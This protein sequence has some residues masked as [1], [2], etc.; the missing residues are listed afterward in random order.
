MIEPFLD[1]YYSVMFYFFCKM[2]IFLL[3]ITIPDCHFF[4]FAFWLYFSLSLSNLFSPLAFSHFCMLMIVICL[5]ELSKR[6]C[7]IHHIFGPTTPPIIFHSNKSI[8]LLCNNGLVLQISNT[9]HFRRRIL[10]TSM[11]I[12]SDPFEEY[13]NPLAFRLGH[14]TINF[15]I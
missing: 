11:H 2:I 8:L 7:R 1:A 5:C 4:F 12:F 10:G 9:N 14:N 15:P 6:K 3:V 13:N